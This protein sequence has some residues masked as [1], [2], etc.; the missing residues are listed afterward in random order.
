[1]PQENTSSEN[2][3]KNMVGLTTFVNKHICYL[4]SYAQY[5]VFWNSRQLH[6]IVIPQWSW[7]LLPLIKNMM[8]CETRANCIVFHTT[9]IMVSPHISETII[10]SNITHNRTYEFVG[11]SKFVTLPMLNLQYFVKL[12]SPYEHIMFCETRANCISNVIPQWSWPHFHILW[13]PCP[14]LQVNCDQL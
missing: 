11:L 10:G 14:N 13:K 5:T 8:F 9:V 6:S 1:M 2:N 12:L 3:H 7:S 4:N